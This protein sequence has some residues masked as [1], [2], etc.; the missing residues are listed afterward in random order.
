MERHTTRGGWKPV[1]HER[2]LKPY[3]HK[4]ENEAPATNQ[5]LKYGLA[6]NPDTQGSHGNGREKLG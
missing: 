2:I 5:Q 3:F 4:D 1:K 6:T